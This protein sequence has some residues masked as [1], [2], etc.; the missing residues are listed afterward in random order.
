VAPT[1][2]DDDD[3]DPD[4]TPLYVPTPDEGKQIVGVHVVYSDDHA[5]N[6]A[7]RTGLG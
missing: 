1:D 7:D 4:D 6:P 5:S 3:D 2:D